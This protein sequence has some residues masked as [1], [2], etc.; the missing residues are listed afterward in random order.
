MGL[1]VYTGATFFVN[2]QPVLQALRYSEEYQ[3][4]RV[5][6]SQTFHSGS[7]SE[8]R[9]HLQFD[10]KLHKTGAELQRKREHDT[11]RLSK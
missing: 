6:V 2:V 1:L 10:P 4:E 3:V 11:E 7:W 5:F 8:K 9:K